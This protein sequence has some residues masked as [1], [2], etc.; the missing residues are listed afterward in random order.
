MIQDIFPKKLYNHYDPSA[1]PDGESRIIVEGPDG[2]L[3]KMSRISDACELMFPRFSEIGSTGNLT[4]LFSVDDEKYFFAENEIP[5][6]PEDYEF[7]T[8]NTLRDMRPVPMHRLY[9]A[10][11]AH[12]LIAWY[13]QNRFC[14][15]CG[16]PTEQ[17][18]AERALRCPSCG[19][20]IFPK[21]MPVVI[22][23]VRNGD[24]MLCTRY[25]RGFAPYALIAGFT[26]IGETLEETCEREVMEEAGIRIK[27]ITYFGSQPWGTA[28]DILAG[29][30]CD[31]DGSPEIHMDREELRSA[32]WKSRDEIEL[33][34]YDYSLTNEI[35]KQFKLGNI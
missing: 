6:V 28:Q 33:Q 24:R 20:L 16:A 18:A 19:N 5:D 25:R 32:E 9:A 13:R 26:E 27:N 15:C 1:E 21:I 30:Y 3:T 7:R 35:M 34:P 4:Y 12:H 2:I 11:T 31:L 14:G 10:F 23:G 29:F 8:L 22:V 17:D